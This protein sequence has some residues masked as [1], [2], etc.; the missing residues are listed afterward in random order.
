MVSV[1]ALQKLLAFGVA[2]T[3]PTLIRAQ[4]PVFWPADLAPPQIAVPVLSPGAA[5]HLPRQG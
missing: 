4:F 2:E 1:Q 5:V 3:K